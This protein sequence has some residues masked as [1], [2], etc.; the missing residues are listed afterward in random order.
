MALLGPP[1]DPARVCGWTNAAEAFRRIASSKSLFLVNNGAGAKYLKEI[2][3]ISAD[4]YEKGN[5][6]LKAQIGRKKGRSGCCA[7]ACV[8]SLGTTAVP[9][10]EMP[11][12]D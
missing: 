8:R 12:P 2:L 7:E 3:W 6:Y 11:G 10:I 9:E 4:V 5:W 1:E